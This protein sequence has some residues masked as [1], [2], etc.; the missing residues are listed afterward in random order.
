[1]VGV[2]K[3]VSLGNT[4]VFRATLEMGTRN[5]GVGGVKFGVRTDVLMLAPV[6]YTTC[7][8]AG[9]GKGVGT[10]LENIFAVAC[11]IGVGW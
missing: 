6:G 5:N 7:I 8:K 9:R 4:S 11:S 3:T 1:M 10:K 2:E